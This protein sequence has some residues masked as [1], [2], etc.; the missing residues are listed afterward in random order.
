MASVVASR[1]H[2]TVRGVGDQLHVVAGTVPPSP[3]RIT[4]ASGSVQEAR[5]KKRFGGRCTFSSCSRS[6]SR[7]GRLQSASTLSRSTP[8]GA[9]WRAA[10][11]PRPRLLRVQHAH[12]LARRR[13]MRRDLFLAAKT[14]TPGIGFNLGSIQRDAV[15]E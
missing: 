9:G 14:V 1:S 7:N 12:L 15:P 4:W 13:Q 10:A 2:Q 11:F 6:T 3:L 8:P 5:A